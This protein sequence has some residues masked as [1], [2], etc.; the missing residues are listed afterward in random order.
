MDV[1]LYHWVGFL[2]LI[3]FLLGFDLW[4]SYRNPHPIEIKEAAITSACWISLALSFNVWIYYQFGSNQ[5]LDF[6]TGYLLEESLSVDNLFVFLLIFSHFKV[7]E[8]AKH[9]VLFYGVLGAIIMRALLITGGI[10]LVQHF[11]WIFIIFG[12]FLVF[13]GIKLGF[14]SKKELEFEE[15]VFL[16]WLRK[17]IPITE[18]YVGNS[19]I[20][21]QNNRWIATPLFVVLILIEF[22]DLVFA[23]DSVPAILAIT[24]E[25]FIVFTSNIFAILGLRALFFA[26]EGLMKGFYLLHHA[27]AF[28]LVFI[29]VKMIFAHYI[30]ISTWITLSVLLASITLAILGSM[31]FPE[32]AK[33]K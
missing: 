24:T 25:P 26:L 16:R 11:E 15:N 2:T 10:A 27:L 21:K 23:L 14:R 9:E 33:T 4:R 13:S 1:S 20:L 28:I 6:L 30:H 3:L 19:F 17:K 12:L 8:N 7:P 18:N 32:K 31:L 5:A 22:T 29:G